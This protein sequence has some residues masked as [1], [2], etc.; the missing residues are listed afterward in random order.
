MIEP[1]SLLLAAA[2]AVVNSG[3]G[4][5]ERLELRLVELSMAAVFMVSL[6]VC[7]T[8]LLVA[9]TG[10]TAGGPLMFVVVVVVVVVVAA[11]GET[12]AAA[13]VDTVAVRMLD[14]FL[15]PVALLCSMRSGASHE[16][17]FSLS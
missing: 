8:L 6:G 3:L 1:P 17:G 2:A 15:E 9:L 7:L 13:G 14:G 16:S 11:A 12:G 5:G 4:L 10:L